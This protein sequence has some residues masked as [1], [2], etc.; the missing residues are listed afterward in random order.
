MLPKEGTKGK[1][2]GLIPR[3]PGT[4]LSAEYGYDWS[5]QKAASAS[6]ATL[7]GR[8]W[9]W[10]SIPAYAGERTNDPLPSERREGEAGQAGQVKAILQSDQTALG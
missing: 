7:R 1:L 10:T 2:E 3:V 4:F 5:V 6:A 9:A 8:S